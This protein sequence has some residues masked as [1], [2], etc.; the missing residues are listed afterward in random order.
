[1]LFLP[2]IFLIEPQMRDI[3]LESRQSFLSEFKGVPPCIV[4]QTDFAR[5]NR[6]PADD[7]LM[8]HP[9]PT[10]ILHSQN[11]D[12]NQTSTFIWNPGQLRCVSCLKPHRLCRCGWCY[13]MTHPHAG[14]HENNNSRKREGKISKDTLCQVR[15]NW[16]MTSLVLNKTISQER[17]ST[18]TA[19]RKNGL[20][21]K[22]GKRE[23]VRAC[24]QLLS[25]DPQLPVP[26]RASHT[27]YIGNG[28]VGIT[29][30]SCQYHAWQ[31]THQNIRYKPSESEA[32]GGNPEWKLWKRF[33]CAMRPWIIMVHPW[34]C[35]EVL[36]KRVV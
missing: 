22:R 2:I 36:R 20:Q 5:S 26:R 11:L 27:R 1:M 17:E 3:C 35:N 31:A 25:L 14:S 29:R 23:G 34:W 32:R 4:P 6:W 15:V 33:W 7:R 28:C 12:L 24:E 16:A 9:P 8:T 19:K 18:C 13:V 21:W 10:M 30:I